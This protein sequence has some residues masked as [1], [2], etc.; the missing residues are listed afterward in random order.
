MAANL[1]LLE[2]GTTTVADWFDVDARFAKFI[3]VEVDPEQWAGNWYNTLGFALA[4]GRTWDELRDIFAE[5]AEW[6]DWFEE[7][8]DV[9][10]WHSF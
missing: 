9:H 1:R 5:R 4:C 2:K 8:F 7:N 6:V 3:G 10:T